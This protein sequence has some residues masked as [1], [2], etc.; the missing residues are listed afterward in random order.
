MFY[1]KYHLGAI[2]YLFKCCI[3]KSE[4]FYGPKMSFPKK[5][6]H[7]KINR[8]LHSSLRFQSKSDLIWEFK[9]SGTGLHLIWHRDGLS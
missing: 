3:R 2:A 4:Q 6:E 8:Y 9:V 5:K 7:C 1:I